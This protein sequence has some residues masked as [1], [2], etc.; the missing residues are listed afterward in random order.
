MVESGFAA[1][2]AQDL[3]AGDLRKVLGVFRQDVERLTGVLD[4]NAEAGES[5]AF[6]HTCHA[7]AGAAGAVGAM[8]LERACRLGMTRA[9]LGPAQLAVLRDDIRALA[10][11]ALADMVEFLASLPPG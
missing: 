10:A 8:A 1:E 2:L 4:T 6:R 3:D 5:V 9:D 7:L 11:A